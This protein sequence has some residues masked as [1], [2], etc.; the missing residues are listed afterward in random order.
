MSETV[1]KEHFPN[2]VLAS[3]QVKLCSHTGESIDV[4]G[5]FDVNVVYK[6]QSVQLSLVVVKG[7]GTALMGRNWLEVLQLDWKEIFSC[8]TT[9][10]P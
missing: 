1:F 4:V 2:Q 7:S 6:S 3:S 5:S 8:S 10:C 9:V